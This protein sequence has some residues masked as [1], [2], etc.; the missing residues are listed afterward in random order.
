MTLHLA[1]SLAVKGAVRK[2]DRISQVG[3]QIHASA[4]YHKVV[5]HVRSGTW[6][7]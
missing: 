4:N 1:E 2:H 3:T 5:D 7:D 6:Q